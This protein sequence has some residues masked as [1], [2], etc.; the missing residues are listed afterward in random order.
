MKS[1][2]PMLVQHALIGLLRNLSIPE[3]NKKPLGD[4]DVIEKLVAMDPWA[5]SRDVLGSVQGGAVGVIKNLVREGEHKQSNCA[6]G[7]IKRDAVP[8]HDGTGGPARAD[9]AHERSRDRNGGVQGVGERYPVIGAHEARG[10]RQAGM[11]H[12]AGQPGHHRSVW[13]D[14]P[15]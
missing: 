7:S 11:G 3:A 2:T 14:L 6:D 4:A 5:E 12:A 9:Q 10:R 8:D 15:R 13:H 1:S